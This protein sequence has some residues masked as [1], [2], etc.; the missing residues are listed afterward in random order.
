MHFFEITMS[1]SAALRT[2]RA[3]AAVHVLADPSGVL[4]ADLEQVPI[5]LEPLLP[6][7]GQQLAQ[8]LIGLRLPPLDDALEGR[9]AR[10]LVQ[11]VGFA[12]VGEVKAECFV[13]C[14]VRD[15]PCVYA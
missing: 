1:L 5:A 14:L 3:G 15:V 10:F 8:L 9:R 4:A 2:E 7:L 11:L 12:G 13:P 6:E